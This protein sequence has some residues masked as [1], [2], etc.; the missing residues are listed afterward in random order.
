MN[1]LE[2]N[3]I[4]WNRQSKEGSRWCTPV[5]SEIIDKAKNGEWIV[6]LTPNKSVP[7]NWFGDIRNKDILCLASGGGQQAP[8][9]AAAGA[10][11]TS[12]DLSE[13]QLNKDKLIS[14]RE[15]LTIKTVQGD[16][17]DLSCFEETR[18]DLIFNPVSTCFVPDV[19][20]IWKEC[21]R[22]LCPGGSLLTGF[23]NPMYYI[24]DVDKAD[25]GELEVKYK[26]PYSD[27]EQLEKEKIEQMEKDKTAFEFSHT[28]ENQIGGQIEAG[29]TITGFYEDWWE[30]EAT[31]LNK[32]TPTFIA[33]KATKPE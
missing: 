18:F 13:E 11:V 10:N 22:L 21:F 6:I 5:D 20:K 8:V 27:V 33:T 25:R 23:L 15:G 29:F 19:K 26:L 12:F 28:L 30:D 2:Y 1:Y 4:S 31:P 7:K 32:F 14:E 9:L 24:F 16:M 3:R 17:A